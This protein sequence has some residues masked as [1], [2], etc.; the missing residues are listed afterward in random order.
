MSLNRPQIQI[1]GNLTDDPR[2]HFTHTGMLAVEFTVA[3][4]PRY[5]D[6]RGEWQEEPAQF[7]RVKCWGSSG[8][9]LMSTLRKGA[10]VTVVGSLRA[11]TWTDKETGAERRG[12]EIIPDDVAVSLRFQTGRF[13]RVMGSGSPQPPA[14]P[15]PGAAGVRPQ[16]PSPAQPPAPAGAHSE[17]APSERG[18]APAEAAQ[19]E[20]EPA[21]PPAPATAEPEPAPSE[22]GVPPAEAGKRRLSRDRSPLPE[23]QPEPEGAQSTAEPEPEKTQPEPAPKKTRTSAKKRASSKKTQK[24]EE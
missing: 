21:Q 19:P 4:N 12:Y 20:P 23:A 2:H 24:A 1:S 6:Q 18:T 17:P 3:V 11:Y 9:N 15:E 22:G 8:E 16:A 13:G 10:H 7:W 5:R 14:Q